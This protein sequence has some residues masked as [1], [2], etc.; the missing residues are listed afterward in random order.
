MTAAD[1]YALYTC[2]YRRTAA[3]LCPVWVAQHKPVSVKVH[4]VPIL[5]FL[6]IYP[7]L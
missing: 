5:S 3:A 7:Q 2:Q 6:R 1:R 4:I